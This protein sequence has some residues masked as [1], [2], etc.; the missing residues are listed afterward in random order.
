MA[1]Q[2]DQILERGDVVEFG[3]VD[4]AHEHVA[5]V[6]A[7]CNYVSC[8]SPIPPWHA[9]SMRLDRKLNNHDEAITAILSAIREL[10]ISTRA[11][12]TPGF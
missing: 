11:W 1:L 7:G 9:S 10:M 5:D 12:P 2:G 4:Q 8:W 6:G 3:G